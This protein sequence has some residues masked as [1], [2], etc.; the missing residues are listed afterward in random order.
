MRICPECGRKIDSP[1]PGE[2]FTM[3]DHLNYMKTAQCPASGRRFV[4][5]SVV[6][7]MPTLGPAHT[8]GMRRSDHR[9]VALS[10]LLSLGGFH[11][12]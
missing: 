6:Y 4:N 10:A 3:P 11:G 5:A 2:S 9:L 8:G 1:P 7:E 12:R